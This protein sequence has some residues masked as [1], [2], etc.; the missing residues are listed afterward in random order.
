MSRSNQVNL[1]N[2]TY[3]KYATYCN[4]L[5]AIAT[6]SMHKKRCNKPQAYTASSCRFTH[7]PRNFDL[8]VF[9]SSLVDADVASSAE[10]FIFFYSNCITKKG[11]KL[12]VHKVNIILFTKH[13][14]VNKKSISII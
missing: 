3:A 7:P 9:P 2:R 10:V 4:N 11:C 6:T 13:N 5:S 8:E 12:V 1:L 14:T